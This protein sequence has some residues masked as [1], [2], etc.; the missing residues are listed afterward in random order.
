MRL[1][2]LQACRGGHASDLQNLT[3]LLDSKSEGIT[4]L[5]EA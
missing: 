4:M 2:L 3:E 5:V 1:Q